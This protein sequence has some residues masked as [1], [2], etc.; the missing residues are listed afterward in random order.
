MATDLSES[1]DPALA[2]AIELARLLGGFIDLTYVQERYLPPWGD[3]EA[4]DMP[5]LQARAVEHIRSEME[6]RLARI[7]AAGVACGATRLEGSPF[8]EIVRHAAESGA[9]L[10]VVGTHGRTGLRH[11]LLGSVAERVVQKAGRPV[12]VVPSP[13]ER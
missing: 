11:V 13:L 8:T 5:E 2:A 9:D 7:R 6:L 10:V 1:S 4:P 3:A 12:L